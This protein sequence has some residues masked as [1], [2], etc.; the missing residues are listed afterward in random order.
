MKLSHLR[1]SRLGT[2]TALQFHEV[3]LTVAAR[4][5]LTVTR[6]QLVHDVIANHDTVRTVASVKRQLQE[7][8]D[9]EERQRA[10][11]R[12]KSEVSM[13]CF[14]LIAVRIAAIIYPAPSD[15]CSERAIDLARA[16]NSDFLAHPSLSV[17]DS[18]LGNF[19][20]NDVAAA[21]RLCEWE[22]LRKIAHL[23]GARTTPLAAE[24]WQRCTGDAAQ[25]AALKR[26][27]DRLRVL[28][29]AKDERADN[30]ELQNPYAGCIDAFAPGNA[31]L[32][33]ST[34]RA[35]MQ[36][37]VPKV[38]S[39][40]RGCLFCC[41]LLTWYFGCHEWLLFSSANFNTASCWFILLCF[42]LHSTSCS[43]SSVSNTVDGRLQCARA[44]R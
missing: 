33:T 10:E 12:A 25:D 13:L 34:V 18:L 39:R 22:C 17:L 24:Q 1:G 35:S 8:S 21:L 15:A 37:S 31:H 2:K 27:D 43:D 6:F 3:E 29:L 19:G 26:R 23:R 28:F 40:F 32:F 36:D 42:L 7:D 44:P 14:C 4:S 30:A 20:A 9:A 11:L 5:K 16:L 38:N 41:R